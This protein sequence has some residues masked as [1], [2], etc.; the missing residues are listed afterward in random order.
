VARGGGRE[1]SDEYAG[2]KKGGG[3]GR[4]VLLQTKRRA[5]ILP[6]QVRE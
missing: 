6:E 5:V 3:A 4:K 1:V 2:N